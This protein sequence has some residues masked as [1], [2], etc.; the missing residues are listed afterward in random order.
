MPI[1]EANLNALK[2]MVL[3][4]PINGIGR[5]TERDLQLLQEYQKV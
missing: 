2:S 5:D 1:R 3:K 4:V